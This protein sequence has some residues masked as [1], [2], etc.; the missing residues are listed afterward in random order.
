MSRVS[1]RYAAV[2]LLAAMFT[3]CGGGGDSP[4]SPPATP[5]A[6]IAI[7]AATATMV[8]GATTPVAVT[9]TRGGGFAGAVTVTASSLTAGVTSSTEIIAA[10][11]TSATITLTAASTAA[12]AIAVPTSITGTGSGVTIA[13]Q[14]LALT[15]T[16]TAGAT[17]ALGSATG[18]VQTGS[19]TTVAVTLTRTGGFTGAVT[20]AATSL[21]TGVTV[22]SQVIAAGAT[23]ATLT[24]AAATTATTGAAATS[25]TATG[26]GVTIA[27]QPYAL[28]VSAPASAIAQI[29]SDI[30]S[31]DGNFAARMALSANGNRLVVSAYTTANGTTRVY[32]KNGTAWVQV[33]AD[34]V[35][36][37]A[38][39][40]A[41]SSVDINAAGT[42]IAIG[43]VFNNGAAASAGHVRVYDLV[44]ST[45]TQVGADIDGNSLGDQFGT[46]VALSG[47]G[48]RLIAG[49]SRGSAGGGYARVY[50][51]VNG[52]W[53]Q[54]GATLAPGGDEGFGYAVDVSADGTTIAISDPFRSLGN[55]RPGS[56]YFYRLNGATWTPLGNTLVGT[57]D[58]DSFGFSFS[59]SSSGTR[60]AVSAPGSTESG[61]DG[62]GNGYGQVR[63]YDLVGGTWTAVGSKINGSAAEISIGFGVRLSDDGTRLAYSAVGQSIAI[64]MTFNGGDWARTGVTSLPVA[65]ARAEG[66][67]LSAD[68]RTI[69]VGTINGSPRRARVFSITP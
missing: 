13:P 51:L 44:G 56:V 26:T 55:P 40:R 27:P 47:S 8:A 38:N 34:I 1:S 35:G 3:A 14:A 23:T 48:S 11:A 32:E 33:G 41:G 64:V 58:Q 62:G 30:T 5:T 63:V 7:S 52:T 69:A 18:T 15:V 36:E 37:A 67:A 53:T 24:I 16:P 17:I 25:I 66:L 29:G 60:V 31:P 46:S 6:A 10:G 50:D 4:V 43:A 9:L 54:V 39:D 42:R 20:V 65:T 49:A 12:A 61:I 45:W 22:A 28:T 57:N 19:S 59:L 2:M 21:P 68:G